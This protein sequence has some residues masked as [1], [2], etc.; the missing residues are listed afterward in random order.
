M[1]HLFVICKLSLANKKLL[2]EHYMHTH[3]TSHKVKTFPLLTFNA[4]HNFT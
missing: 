1:I 2:H 4:F 3:N